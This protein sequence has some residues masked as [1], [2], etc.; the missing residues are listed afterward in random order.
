MIA[1]LRF[2][3]DRNPQI[4]TVYGC[5]TAGEGWR[6]LRMRG[7]VLEVDIAEYLIT[8]PDRILGLILHFVGIT[9]AAPAVA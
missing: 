6:F 3:R 5:V 8:E 4:T 7:S 9:P 1:A 2:H